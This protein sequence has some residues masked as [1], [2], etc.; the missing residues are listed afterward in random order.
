VTRM[1]LFTNRKHL[2]DTENEFVVTKGVGEE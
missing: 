1:N 2:T